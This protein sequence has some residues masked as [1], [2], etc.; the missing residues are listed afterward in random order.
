VA[1]LLD[2]SRAAVPLET[3]PVVLADAGIDSVNAQVDALISAGVPRRM[4][5]LMELKFSN[6]MIEACWRPDSTR[7]RRAYPCGG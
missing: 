5:V 2:A 1:V 6:S 4:L 7:G 3:T